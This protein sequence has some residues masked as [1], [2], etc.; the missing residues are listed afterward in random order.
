[1]RGVF[2]TTL[3]YSLAKL[4]GDDWKTVMERELAL[5]ETSAWPG[6]RT[7]GRLKRMEDR[8]LT[9]AS[10][11]G[12]IAKVRSKLAGAFL[13][14]TDCDVWLTVDDDCEAEAEDVRRLVAACRGTGAVVS[15]PMLLRGFAEATGNYA[16]NGQRHEVTDYPVAP[17][18]DAP[19]SKIVLLGTGKTGLGLVALHRRA[20]E[21]L[22]EYAEDVDDGQGGVY[23]A[24]FLEYVS[25][26]QW[27]SDDVGFS[28]RARAA[29]VPLYVLTEA[30]GTHAGRVCKLGADGQLYEREGKAA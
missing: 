1:M 17:P 29:Q 12:L 2:G 4:A 27:I 28:A 9:F 5:G 19:V 3:L 15:M 7:L 8:V 26:R 18:F 16:L 6:V 25:D 22:S 20:V 21:R 10:G 23:P 30:A 24:L 14:K 13:H 11:N